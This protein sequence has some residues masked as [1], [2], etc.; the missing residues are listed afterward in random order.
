M[1]GPV[2]RFQSDD[3]RSMG[4]GRWGKHDNHVVV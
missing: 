1:T 2:P 4:T 3:F